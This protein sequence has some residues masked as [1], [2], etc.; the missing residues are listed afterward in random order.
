MEHHALAEFTV[1]TSHR[2]MHLSPRLRSALR[3]VIRT[4]AAA[5]LIMTA[6]VAHVDAQSSVPSTPGRDSVRA[7]VVDTVKVLGRIDDLI[8]SARSAS[9]GH[10]RSGPAAAP[11]H[12]RG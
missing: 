8:G 12:A 11:D 10:R 9:E 2:S 3:T 6:A 4:S 5:A 7:Q 1:A